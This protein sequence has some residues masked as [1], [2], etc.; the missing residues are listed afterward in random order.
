MG[1]Q[2]S[3]DLLK[4]VYCAR[5]G[6]IPLVLKAV[7]LSSEGRGRAEQLEF[8]EFGEEGYDG[9]IHRY[10]MEGRGRAEIAMRHSETRVE[11]AMSIRGREPIESAQW[12]ALVRAV[13]FDSP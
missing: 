6:V 4:F 5:F 3:F 12:A 7:L 2:D 13:R 11:I 10:T 9:L 8:H 1:V